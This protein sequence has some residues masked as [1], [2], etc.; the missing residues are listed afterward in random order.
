[1]IAHLV[2]HP[3]RA[4]A[5]LAARPVEKAHPAVRANQPIFNGHFPRP[6]M[7]PPDQIFPIE[8]LLPIARLG[9]GVRQ[10][11]AYYETQQSQTDQHGT[12][13]RRKEYT[14]EGWECAL[15]GVRAWHGY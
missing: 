10:Q 4:V 9:V 7:F 11:P 8:Q 3:D 15:W 2:Y 6:D 1:M 13:F 14:T 12:T 5:Q